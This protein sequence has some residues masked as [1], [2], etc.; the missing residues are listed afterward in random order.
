MK[1]IKLLLF[2]MSS[3]ILLLSQTK[4]T[5]QK[6]SSTIKIQNNIYRIIYTQPI[7]KDF[8]TNGIIAFNYERKIINAFS[9]ASKLGVA[10]SVN[11]FGDGGNPYQISFHLFSSIEARYYFTL[12]RRLRKGKS[13]FN[14]S[15]PYIS[16]EQNLFSNQ[17][18][19][20]NQTAKKSFEGYT[21]T[22]FNLGY[23][24]QITNFYFAA[25]IGGQLAIKDFS[26]YDIGRSLSPFHVGLTIG[27]V[28]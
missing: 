5:K 3:P 21:A 14:F 4:I 18:A 15:S 10:T 20:I 8:E 27:Y 1:Q 23:Q 12:N 6:D 13:V 28:F 26:K 25:Y 16:L 17:F 22:Y 19:L 11:K 7:D 9:V 24:K 2:I